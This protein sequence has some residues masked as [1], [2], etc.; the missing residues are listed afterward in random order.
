MM[1]FSYYVSQVFR[2]MLAI[3][4]LVAASG[5]LTSFASFRHNLSES[6]AVPFHLNAI[7]AAG[8]IAFEYVLVFLLLIHHGK[9]NDWAMFASLI[10]FFV[11]TAVVGFRYLTEGIVRCSCF[12]EAERP[13][14]VYDIARNLLILLAIS[15]Y[16]FHTGQEQMNR[17]MA[18][19]FLFGPALILSLY[20]MNFHEMIML[21]KRAHG[22]A[23]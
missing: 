1:D 4:L 10:L 8:I 9:L 7:L 21:F 14:S 17:Y 19:I 5:K 20:L 13:V 12:G 2:L 3:L 22:G 11:F 15:F 23:R 16:L 18:D 6:F